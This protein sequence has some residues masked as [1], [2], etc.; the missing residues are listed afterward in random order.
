[1]KTWLGLYIVKGHWMPGIVDH[2]NAQINHT[3]EHI[4]LPPQMARSSPHSEI[5][6][7]AQLVHS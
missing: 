4:S 7:F 5:Y 3:N 1:M 2:V 6:L